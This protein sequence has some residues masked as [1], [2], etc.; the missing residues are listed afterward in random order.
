MPLSVYIASDI[1]LSRFMTSP[2]ELKYTIGG[3]RYRTRV[4]GA[5]IVGPRAQYLPIISFTGV[6][7]YH[8]YISSY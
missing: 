4:E 1:N 6:C 2:R 5:A 3:N 7:T 8:I